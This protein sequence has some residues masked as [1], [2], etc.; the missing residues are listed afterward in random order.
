MLISKII[1]N[2]LQIKIEN[3]VL[4]KNKN[5]VP[6]STLSKREREKNIK[7]A[8]KIK[9]IEKVKNKKILI[10]DDIYTTGSTLNECAKL[11]LKSGIKKENIGVLT[12]AKD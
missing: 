8:F 7:R 11:L 5:I 2:I 4:Y 6:Q 9:D 3:K 1:S 12:L 10:I